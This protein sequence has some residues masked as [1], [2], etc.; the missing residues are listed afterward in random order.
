MHGNFLPNGNEF[1]FFFFTKMFLLKRWGRRGDCVVTCNR[2]DCQSKMRT[3]SVAPRPVNLP[4]IQE[5][6]WR[7][8]CCYSCALYMRG[9]KWL[10]HLDTE[11]TKLF[12]FFFLFFHQST[13]TH[14]DTHNII[15][16]DSC[17][18]E[19]RSR[20][21]PAAAAAGSCLVAA[22]KYSIPR[23]SY[24]DQQEQQQHSVRNVYITS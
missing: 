21:A 4:G 17:C 24:S 2:G 15:I 1:S 19:R 6:H 10:Y 22:R 20:V 23:R 9:F 13:T 12:F 11:E 7:H 5:K 16:T 3:H 8:I 18:A 14:I